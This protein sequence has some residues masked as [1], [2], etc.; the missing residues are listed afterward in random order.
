M[1]EKPNRRATGNIQARE[2]LDGLVGASVS[3]GREF[4]VVRSSNDMSVLLYVR[5]GAFV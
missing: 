2:R 1:A 4:V 3:D 5:N